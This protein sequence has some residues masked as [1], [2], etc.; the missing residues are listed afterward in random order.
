M[1]ATEG[2]RRA[3]ELLSSWHNHRHGSQR[4]GFKRLVISYRF[5]YAPNF[6]LGDATRA[7]RG[8]KVGAQGGQEEWEGACWEEGSFDRVMCDVPC[9]GAS[10]CCVAVGHARS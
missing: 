7:V 3:Q 6:P 10:G 1:I 9:S 5:V 2:C 4:W 8:W